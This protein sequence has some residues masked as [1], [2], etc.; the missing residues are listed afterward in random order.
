MEALGIFL[1]IY[2][3]FCIGIGLFKLPAVWDLKKL[4]V[5]SRWLKGDTNLQVFIIIFGIVSLIV[6]IIV[7]Q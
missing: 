5:I 3:L 2:G 4:R 7:R 6:G 1:I